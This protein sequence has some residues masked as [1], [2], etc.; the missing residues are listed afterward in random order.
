MVE[1]SASPRRWHPTR[2]NLGCDVPWVRR[3]PREGLLMLE[4]DVRRRVLAETANGILRL[5]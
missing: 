5:G 2:E 3:P 4:K 1:P